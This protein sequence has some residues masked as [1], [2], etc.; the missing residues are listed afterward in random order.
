MGMSTIFHKYE[1]D[2]TL[3]FPPSPRDWLPED[4]LVW[5]V[6]ETVEQLDIEGL[7]AKYRP[8]GKGNLAYHPRMMLKILVYAYC[9]GVFSSRKIAR[10]IE[11][12]VAFR[13]LAAGYFPNHRTICR[14]RE[15]HLA[16]FEALFVQ[17]VQIAL[18]AGLAKMGT[19]ALD[20][21][22]VK[23]NA[24]KHKAMS[25]KRMQEEEKRLTR[26]IRELTKKARSQ[27]TVE[28]ETYGPD[29]RGDELPQ[30]IRRRQSRLQTIRQARQRLEER[31]RAEAE[32]KAFGQGAAKTK[33]SKR[34][35][36]KKKPGRPRVHPEGEPRPKDQENFTDPDSRIMKVGSKGFEQC[37]NTEIAVDACGQIIVG[38]GVTQN[39]ADVQQLIPMI[40]VVRANTQQQPDKVLADAGYRS[41]PNFV[42]LETRGISGFV[43]LGREGKKASS[44]DAE[45]PATRRMAKRMQGKRGRKTYKARKYVVEP[46]FGWIKQVLGFRAFSLRGLDKVSGEWDLVCLA[47]NLKRMSRLVAWK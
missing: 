43:P 13:L 15:R 34:G 11:E 41:E 27:D 20:G 32:Q 7:L 6:S 18:E 26:E 39:A 35:K 42:E 33:K 21:S 46:V 22:K 12:N 40:D 5:F 2:Q 24:S 29:F 8:G 28:D 23:A 36:A 31:K 9:T 17:V 30:E 47:L 10:Q 4:H 14:F 44:S 45:Y 3:L 1:P 38:T 16:E 19:I 37:Y 25:Y